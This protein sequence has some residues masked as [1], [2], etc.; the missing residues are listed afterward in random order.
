MN[1]VAEIKERRELSW[2]QELR[3][4]KKNKERIALE[5]ISMPTRDF[6]PNIPSLY[7]ED[8]LGLSDEEALREAQRCLDC[9]SP[10]CVLSCPANIQI[11]SFI[12]NIERGN[13]I[14]AWKTLRESS[15]LS[16]ICSRVCAQ[17]KQ[18]EGGCTYGVN[19]KKSPVSIGALERYVANFEARHR[20]EI[21]SL[22]KPLPYN[23]QSVA[24]IGSG[25]A[26]LAAAHDLV[27]LGYK[28]DVYEG[29]SFLG[30]VMRTG[31]P[32]FR[33]PA[34]VI[35]DEVNRLKHYG[36]HFY[37]NTMIGKDVSLET[38]RSRHNYR[39][40]FIATGAGVSRRMG[41]KGED[42][43]GVMLAGDY[44]N[45]TNLANP[46][47]AENT[48]SPLRAKRVAVI[49]GG[50]TALDV[51]RTAIRL[52]AEEAMLIYRRSQAE[53][54]A[55]IKEIEEALEE[56]AKFMTLYNP[57]AYNSD[58]NGKLISVDIERMELGEADESGRRSP[59]PTG[60]IKTIPIDLAVVSVGVMPHP[61]IA[62]QLPNLTTG[63][64]GNII[65]NA[66]Q[67]TTIPMFFSGGDSVRGG[68]TVVHAMRD[69]RRAA[70]S[71]HEKLI[72]V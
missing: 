13:L 31:I 58:A 46:K 67:A 62:E 5:K 36:V 43:E 54:P 51:V 2:R 35:D 14:E 21:H 9:P 32:R 15:T 45:Q 53:M 41:I 18:C 34:E 1:I 61:L 57:V 17:Y 22:A 64:N 68:A 24:V 59:I 27:L 60:E 52:G 28:V 7:I 11:P 33:L 29:R 10:G 40:F 30:G 39:A 16:A 56:G 23:G 63:K 66:E 3:K 49:G 65:V 47:F 72:A 26:G 20:S 37:L 8:K 69:G 71:I 42:L 44:L 38:L 25:P 4:Q 55:N 50:N 12:K 70:R 6:T 48:L 19:L